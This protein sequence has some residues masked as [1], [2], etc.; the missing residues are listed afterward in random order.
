MKTHDQQVANAVAL[1]PK[2]NHSD[3]FLKVLRERVDAYFER[4]GRS[5]RDSPHMY[6]KTATILAWFFG[7]Y[8]LLLFAVSHWWLVLPLAIVLGLALAA[9][10]FNIQHDGGHK[11]YSKRP[12]VNKMM[13]MVLDLMGGSSYMWDWKH[14]SIHHTYTNITGHDDDIDLGF[15]ARLTPHQ[16]R[17]W[18]H[19]LQGIYLWILYGFLSI[20]WHFY[21]D[22]R[23]IAVGRIGD[24]KIPRP[25]GMELA[26]F[27]GGK[28]IFFS[29]AFV[30]PMLLHPIWA[31]LAVYAI[32]AFVSGIV[33]G[34]VFQLA[35]CVEEAGFPMPVTTAEGASQM[36][37]DW[38][39]HEVQTTVDFS[40]GNRI[41]GWFVGGLNYQIEHHLFP[42]ICHVHYPE[43]SKIVE[44]VCRDFGVRY[45]TNPTFFSAIASHYR[46]LSAMGRPSPVI[47]VG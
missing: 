21:D 8:F 43:V 28:T 35:H 3:R 45:S 12:W 18:F 24:K 29:M 5:K 36:P 15:L 40:R 13:A 26:L 17:Y 34:I 44:G 31:V 20:K 11:S 37:T 10:G 38:A 4:T 2:F 27:I 30:V 41:L 22:F 23:T 32:A 25:K 9:I 42:K 6:F 19:R 39:L 33:L 46:W 47:G 16:R 14:N 1:P 7:A